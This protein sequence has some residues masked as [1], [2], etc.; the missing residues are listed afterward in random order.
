MAVPHQSDTK[1]RTVPSLKEPVLSRVVS[2][3]FFACECFCVGCVC[4]RSAWS[5]IADFFVISSCWTACFVVVS[6]QSSSTCCCRVTTSSA[7]SLRSFFSVLRPCLK[8]SLRGRPRTVAWLRPRSGAIRPTPIKSVR[9][10]CG[11][12]RRSI[13]RIP[14]GP[15]ARS[16]GHV[17][18]T[19]SRRD[20]HA[21]ERRINT[22]TKVDLFSPSWDNGW[23]A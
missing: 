21:A 8:P 15:R 14:P 22:V 7:R 20:S 5:A 3:D 17:E 11:T 19:G 23:Y 4:R 10:S 18:L 12:P 13:I 1:F 9:S 2:T 6:Y 16:R